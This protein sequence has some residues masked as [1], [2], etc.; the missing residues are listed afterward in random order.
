MTGKMNEG[1]CL[2]KTGSF[3]GYYR[4]RKSARFY[5]KDRVY[6]VLTSTFLIQKIQGVTN[7]KDQVCRGSTYST[8][9]IIRLMPIHF[10]LK[11]PYSKC[12]G[13]TKMYGS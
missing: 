8:P 11:N 10:V 3:A 2:V 6:R 4:M 5:G 7:G 12:T 13:R 9:H 1:L